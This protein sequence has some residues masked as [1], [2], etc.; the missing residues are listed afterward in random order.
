ML[1]TSI[2]E[3]FPYSLLEAMAAGRA[4]VATDVGGVK[5]AT[6]DAGIVVAPRRHR[7]PLPAAAV[8]L[9]LDAELRRSL[10]QAARQRILSL[11]TVEQSMAHFRDVYRQ[12]TEPTMSTE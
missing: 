5:E 3:G 4:T 2:S 8:R 9:L 1:L 10:G 6:G 11:F 12:V 7:G